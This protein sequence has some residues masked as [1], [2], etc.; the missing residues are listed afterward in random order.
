MSRLVQAAGTMHTL[1]LA[2]MEEASRFGVRDTDIDHLLLALTIDPDTGGQILRGMGAGLDAARAAVAAQH[3]AQLESVGVATGVDEPGRIVFHETSGYEWTDRALA[4]W[5]VAS[6]GRRRGDSAAV[7]RALVDE[8]SGLVEEILRRL[9]VDPDTLRS[10]LDDTRVVDPART[11]RLDEKSFSASRSIFVPAPVEDVWELLS[12]ASRIPE[13]DHGVGEVGSAIAPTGPWEARTITVR[14]GKPVTV[15][16]SYERQQIFL[17]RFEDRAFVTWRFTYPDASIS[18]SRVLAF[19]LE[20]AAGG[21]QI[22]VTLTWE[23]ERRRRGIL[24]SIRRRMLRPIAR[25]VAHI[26]TYFQLTQTES[27]ISRVFR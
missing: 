6:S 25:P 7:L 16:E 19:A 1:S 4:V 9:D 22:Q 13:W 5:T 3:A 26:L 21:M 20:H 10:R 11:D 2:A 23:V 27:G 17:D 18:T 15:K 24:H 12:S 8:P 14:N